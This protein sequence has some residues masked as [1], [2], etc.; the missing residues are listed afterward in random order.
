MGTKTLCFSTEP[1][2]RREDAAA[3]ICPS[4]KGGGTEVGTLPR[5]EG[6]RV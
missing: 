6:A 5:I 2:T 4:L 1:H 3:M